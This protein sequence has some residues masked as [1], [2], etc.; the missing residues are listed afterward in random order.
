MIQ[1]GD[2]FKEFVSLL[3]IEKQHIS[4]EI[5]EGQTSAG[6]TTIGIG[7]KFILLVSLSKKKLHLL[8]GYTMG[9]LES[10]IIV[11]ENGIVDIAN[12][13]GYKVDYFPNGK[14]EV[15]LPHIVVYGKTRVED[16]II[17]C[18]GY[19]DTSKWKDILGN[20][21]GIVAVDEANIADIDFLRELSMRRDYWMM[22]LNPDDPNMPIYGEF[23]NHSR[24][25]KHYES[26][27][28][29][30]LLNQLYSGEAKDG[31]IHW[32]FTMND[33]RA[34]SE[35]KKQQIIDSVPPNSKQYKNKILGLRGR[36]EGLVYEEFTDSKIIPINEF[37][38][39]P[40]EMVSRVI[41]GLDSGLNNDATALV[42]CLLTTAGRLLCIP[43]F[44]YLP[45]IGSNAN[46][47]QAR[48]IANWLN[49]W[50][51][52]FGINITNIVSIF[53]DSAALTQDLIYEIN[54]QTP[55]NA[56]AVEK[57]D[58]LKD[59]QRVK[60]II[61]KD[62]YFYIIDAGYRNPLNP[63]ELLG[64]TDMFIVELNNKVW[65]MKKNQ[66]E[67]GN[68]HC[69]DAFKYGSYYIY[70]AYGGAY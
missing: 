63:E 24:P 57:K 37:K 30:E 56:S 60:S 55:F 14:G 26:D 6:K 67:D 44:Y 49:Y 62:D 70:Y 9:K 1:L 59:T 21:Y 43:S 19:S 58:I 27:Y 40:N 7:L 41:C 17:Y 11:K 36:S 51:P 3:D 54:L 32:Y 28:P 66:P 39:L 31:Y 16:K 22:T 2:K 20:Q 23:I 42:T 45:K 12:Q 34:L 5:L 50:L 8:C 53:G 64:Q 48:N 65:D 4:V 13:L 46:S 15:R 29:K 52:R 47:I 18:A 25:L 10:S 69:I 35:E 33:N 61:G 68:D 38:Y